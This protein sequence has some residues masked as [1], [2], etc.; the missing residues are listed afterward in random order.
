MQTTVYA[1]ESY[2]IADFPHL[3]ALYEDDALEVFATATGRSV[4]CDYGVPGS[5]VW[6]EIEDIQID[7]YEI[8]GVE[9]TH[10][11]LTAKFGDE[12]ADKFHE[13]CA[14]RAAEKGDWE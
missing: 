4:R 2:D 6:Y 7:E 14:D 3:A 1:I 9:Y 5:P 11:T 13:I 10:K 12:L 8:N